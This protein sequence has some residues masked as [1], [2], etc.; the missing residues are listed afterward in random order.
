MHIQSTRR[1]CSKGVRRHPC[2]TL[3]NDED[4]HSGVTQMYNPH[5]TTKWFTEI[6]KSQC[7]LHFTISFIVIWTKASI[8]EFVQQFLNLL[9]DKQN[10]TAIKTHTDATIM[11][12]S[13]LKL[14]HSAMQSP[15]Q[16]F[17]IHCVEC[18]HAN[19]PS[20]GSPTETLLR[21]LL[22]LNDKVHE[23]WHGIIQHTEHCYNPND[24]PDHS[25]GRSDGRC[26]QRAGT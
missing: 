16:Y 9:G 14:Q 11:L 17:M 1:I 13:C 19:D 24:S 23:I 3:N 20:A 18:F 25:I 10:A 7:F 5:S 6:C 2:T 4:M 21:L 12:P 15:K 22:P 8:A 26:V